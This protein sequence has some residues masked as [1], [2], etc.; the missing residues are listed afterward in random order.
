MTT[1]THDWTMEA[2]LFVQ[3]VDAL[4]GTRA[5]A[6]NSVEQEVV[7]TPGAVGNSIGAITPGI[8]A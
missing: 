1:L 8:S 6:L 5:G 3:R 7:S 4:D 2:S